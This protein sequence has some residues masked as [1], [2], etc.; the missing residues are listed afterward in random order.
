MPTY[1]YQCDSCHA[2]LETFQ[3]IH[4]EPL[5]DCPHCQQPKLRRLISGAGVIFK[6][7]GF[8]VNDSK[9]T[10][11]KKSESPAPAAPG[12]TKTTSA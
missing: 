1:D 11:S 10:D 8:Y 6:G 3:S 5:Q 4:D 7:S 2:E 9:K 12:T